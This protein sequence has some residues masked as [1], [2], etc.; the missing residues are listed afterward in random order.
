MK[1]KNILETYG[2]Q[3]EEISIGDLV[4]IEGTDSSN[5]TFVILG[6]IKLIKENLAQVFEKE[7]FWFS[8]NS[9]RVEEENSYEISDLKKSIYDRLKEDREFEQWFEDEMTK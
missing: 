8:G 4:L 2:N 9:A 1:I 3:K 5:G 6:E 7:K